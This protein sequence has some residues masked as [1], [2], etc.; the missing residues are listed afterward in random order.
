MYVDLSWPIFVLCI[1]SCKL[2]H[3][4]LFYKFGHHDT[5]KWRHL[6]FFCKLD[7]IRVSWFILTYSVNIGLDMY[8]L[9]HL[10]WR[11]CPVSFVSLC[12][13][14]IHVEWTD[15]TIK[16]FSPLIVPLWFVYCWYILCNAGQFLDYCHVW[17]KCL[18]IVLVLECINLE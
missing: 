8:K 10:D 9:A 2:I 17:I 14:V 4:D 13:L 1:M 11:W 16:Q 18:R 12:C 5:S 6:D 3:L 15:V 7:L